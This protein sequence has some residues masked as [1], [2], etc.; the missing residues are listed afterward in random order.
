MADR[1]GCRSEPEPGRGR[2]YWHIL[3]RDHPQ[4]QELAAAGQRRLSRFAGLHFTPRQWLHMTTLVAGFADEFSAEE[5]EDMLA[6]V[7]DLLSPVGP[8]TVSFGKVLYHPQAVMLGV[9][10]GGVLDP[11]L[12]AVRAA[13][14]LATAGRASWSTCR[15][16]RTSRWRAA[17]LFSLR[18][19]SSLRSAGNFRGVKPPSIASASS[20]RWV[21]S[22]CGIGAVLPR[23]RSGLNRD[24][25][26]SA[27]HGS[28]FTFHDTLE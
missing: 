13:T 15:G 9:R 7:R 28:G 4:V 20:A 16:R 24:R 8:I 10:P 18:V 12:D 21:R 19:R 23:F 6:R 2:L 3:F 17:R 11:V 26:H 14:R 1:W 27:N 5:T 22:G 25:P